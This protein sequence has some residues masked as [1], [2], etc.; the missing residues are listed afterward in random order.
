MN[1]VAAYY[2]RYI[3]YRRTYVL[4]L[5]LISLLQKQRTDGTFRIVGGMVQF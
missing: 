3:L 5:S 2:T 1:D 4:P